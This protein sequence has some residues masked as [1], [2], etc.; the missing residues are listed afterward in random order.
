M[1]KIEEIS[2]VYET[3]NGSVQALR[4]VSLDLP[5]G[6]FTALLGKSGCGKT[7]LLRLVAGLEA[8]SSGTLSLDLPRLQVGYVFQ[9][10]RLMP[11]LSVAD[12]VRLAELG[13]GG[14]GD[15]DDAARILSVLGLSSF[16]KAF[17]HQL[18]GGMAQR[19]AL[20]RTLFC[21]PSLILMDEPFGALDWF[22]RRSLQ[23]DL[24]RLWQEGGKTILFVTHD[25]DEALM[26]AGRVVVLKDGEVT[27]RFEV[28]PAHRR[29]SSDLFP[30][31][32]RILRTLI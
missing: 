6:S 17:P 1:V 4:G 18:S 19:V 9:E 26:L 20:G 22:T 28:F 5:E 32:E 24:L 2:K 3:K 8:P 31:R 30:L 29:D 27:D 13:G 11:W 7:T 25:I 15:F 14:H 21:K 10:P 12:N 23:E 16:S